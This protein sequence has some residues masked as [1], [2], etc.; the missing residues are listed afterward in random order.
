[1]RVL[2]ISD[3]HGMYESFIE[4]LSAVDY[5]PITDKLILLGDYV[6]RGPEPIKVLQKVLE[7]REQG[8][9][10]LMGNH[11]AM[12]LEAYLGINRN[13]YNKFHLH[14]YNGGA[15][16]WTKLKELETDECLRL[17]NSINELPAY[18]E[19][20]DYIFVHAGVDP[21]NSLENQD[22][23]TL[24]W[25]REEF[26]FSPAY[27][28]KKVV[29]GHT[30]TKYMDRPYRIWDGGDKIGIDCGSVFG[31]KLACLELPSGKEY[32]V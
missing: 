28:D 31:G 12:L 3:I 17:I 5:D 10:V 14:L 18:A 4:L 22:T 8:A 25:A 29:F 24:L 19:F 30:P 6:D 27:K 20:N 26:I 9:T 11:E 2:A 16:T 23:E 13:D 32:Y 15:T 1:M 7:L 21:F